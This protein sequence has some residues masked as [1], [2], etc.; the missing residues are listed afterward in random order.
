MR[1]DQVDL[2]MIHWPIPP[3]PIKTWMKAMAKAV[4]QGLSK[5]VGVSNYNLAQMREAQRQ[6]AMQNLPLASNQ[7]RY[8]LLHRNPEDNGV[9]DFCQRENI[10][11]I[12]YSPLEQGLLTGKYSSENPP[13]F[14]FGRVRRISLLNRLP[15]LIHLMR[16]IGEGHGG[17][18]PA[19]VAINWAH[20]KG[21]VPI[22]GANNVKQAVENLGS[23][24]WR[25]SADEIAIL[26]QTSDHVIKGD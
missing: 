20:C 8:N 4:N 3:V 17:K 14:G 16:E 15:K 24:G 11:L 21:A 9:L 7:V 2:Y 25:L 10:T 6:L 19:Q 23:V 1:L 5:A 18:T 12:A 22:P 13:P 26:E